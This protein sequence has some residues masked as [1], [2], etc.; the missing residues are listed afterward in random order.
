[1]DSNKTTKIVLVGGG[2]ESVGL[3][4]SLSVLR[5]VELMGLVCEDPTQIGCEVA[6]ELGIEIFSH[7]EDLKEKPDLILD[8][9]NL[10]PLSPV[11]VPLANECERLLKI[12]Q[13]FKLSQKYSQLMEESNRVLDQK[14][15]ELSLLNQASGLFRASLD[16][17]SVMVQIFNLIQKRLS[18]SVGCLFLLD[19]KTAECLI[20]A[21]CPLSEDFAVALKERLA[22]L[23][24]I[25]LGRRIS[26]Q[27]LSHFEMRGEKFQPS[28]EKLTGDFK[29]FETIPLRVGS[30]PLGTLAF[31]QKEKEAFGRETIRFFETL[32]NQFSLYIESDRVKNHLAQANSDLEK[33]SQALTALNQELGDFT[34]TVSHDLKEPLRSLEATL[35]FLKE[36]CGSR[37]GKKGAKHVNAMCQNLTKM[38]RFINDLL[39]LSHTNQEE[40]KQD[41]V[42]VEKIIHEVEKSFET[43]SRGKKVRWQLP[44]QFPK[45]V[46]GN[47]LRIA[48]VFG[49]LVSNAVKFC[50]S[51]KPKIEIGWLR[52]E[53]ETLFFVKDNGIGIDK[54]NFKKLFRPFLKLN[55]KGSEGNGI[56][57]AIC[58]KI[59]QEHKGH[60]WLESQ[61]GKGSTFYFTLPR[62]D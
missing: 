5:G 43:D 44:A 12:E 48:Q 62:E 58:K 9:Q 4:R 47:S 41:K 17:R 32:G 31:I 21:N 37:L 30:T 7:G 33:K 1:M 23:A 61:P 59:I 52:Q 50:N 8:T 46:Q 40:K 53:N 28:N 34:F 55:P 24:F 45:D 38:K 27:K 54:S 22:D 10:N 42:D 25:D 15:L 26:V 18:L 20:I 51:P 6:K 16:Y 13:R 57:L 2:E 11:L 19:D 29:S 35:G 36:D 3:L 39:E 14:V 56:D 49:N 60:L